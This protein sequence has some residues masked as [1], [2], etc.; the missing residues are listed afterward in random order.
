MA[1]TTVNGVRLFYELSGTGETP[2]VLVH[3]S[4]DSHQVWDSVVPRLAREFRVLAYD[5]RGHSQS[6]RTDRPYSIREEAADLAALIEERGMAPAHVAGSSS[7]G[8]VALR[9]AASRPDLFRSLAPQV[10]SYLAIPP[11]RLKPDG[12]V[13]SR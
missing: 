8:S 4:W 6:T 12:Q 9:L 3:G 13:A 7:G 11:D 10:L 5:R 2:L 1:T